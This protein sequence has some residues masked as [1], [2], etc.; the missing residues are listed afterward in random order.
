MKKIV[1]A[2]NSITGVKVIEEIRKT[3]PSSEITLLTLEPDLPY[4]VELLPDYLAQTIKEDRLYYKT[5][6]FYLDNAVAT[7]LE[8]KIARINFKKNQIFTEQKDVFPYDV[9]ILTDCQNF[10]FPEIKG[11]NKAG[12]FSLQKLNS[13][14]DMIRALPFTETAVIVAESINAIRMAW[15][16]RKRNK[17]VILIAPGHYL[18]SSAIDAESA[19][20][21]SKI[22][23]ENGVTV[24]NDNAVSEILGEGDAK[25]V[26]LKTGKVL[27]SEMI[28][29]DSVK[30][31]LRIFLD[32]PLMVN[33]GICVDTYLKTN[34][35]DVYAT[36][37][38]CEFPQKTLGW[39]VDLPLELLEECGRAVGSSITGQP[40]NDHFSPVVRSFDLFEVPI[41]F[42]GQ[43]K[44]K[45][46]GREFLQWKP[47]SN[48]YKKIFVDGDVLTGA[49]LINAQREQEKILRVMDEKLNISGIEESVLEENVHFEQLVE[50]SKGKKTPL[51]IRDDLEAL[52]ESM[53][54]RDPSS[55]KSP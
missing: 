39:Q 24:I 37:N 34:L 43:T 7:V 32:T 18:L 12:V 8:K 23:E 33:E 44:L 38:V 2:G 20:T 1:I 48:V 17:D 29:F 14:R 35:P 15:A 30:P 51:E 45:D 10:K 50:L 28:M 19:K 5:A 22:F 3:D 6:D 16:L 41:I 40:I 26:R 52:S 47:E 21:L 54:R 42:I 49:V 27:A 36:N 46:G 25:A 4:R 13:I 11:T 31:D 55:T 53:D 9:L